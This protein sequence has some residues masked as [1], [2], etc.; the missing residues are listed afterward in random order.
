LYY[1]GRSELIESSSE[2]A[3]QQAMEIPTL[4][5]SNPPHGEVDVEAAAKLLELDVFAAGLKAKFAAPEIMS[6]AGPEEAAAFADA[7][8]STGFRVAILD[9]AALRDLPWPDPISAP[10]FDA[11]CMRATSRGEPIEIPYGAETVCVYCRPPA[12]RSRKSTVDL[13]RAVASGYGPTIAQAVQ[14]MSVIDLYFRDEGAV[15]RV[16]VIPFLHGLDG[17]RLIK[18]IGRRFKCLRL[19]DRLAGVR[20]RAHFV[21]TEDGFTGPERR[22]YSFGTAGLSQVLESIAPELRSIPQYEFG[23]RL[24]Y[25][26]SP[27]ASP[28]GSG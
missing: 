26:L 3:R 8:R 14:W 15:R 4:V 23:S 16:S 6:A 10:I 20:P 9:G 5:V 21:M 27:L 19:D 28:V 25:A 22:R 12:D 18:E 24:A 2:E 11:S 13:E 7:L 1:I 17:E